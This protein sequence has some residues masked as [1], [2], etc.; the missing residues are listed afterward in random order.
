M[1]Y[2]LGFLSTKQG[3]NCVF[4]VVDQFS[5]MAILTTYKK[6]VIVEYTT[7]IF[8]ERVWVHFGIP[9]TIIL[10]RYNR[11]LKTFRL[12]LW[13]LLDTKLTK[14]TS[15]HPQ[16][17]GQM[18]VCNHMTMHILH[19]YNYKHPCAWDKSIPYV[20]HS[21]NRCIHSSTDH[22]PF[23]LGLGFPLLGPIDVS[24]PLAPHRN[25]IPLIIL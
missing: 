4:A 23:Q 9:Y 17:D 22:I 5:Q 6:N 21:Y 8:F 25:N 7:N 2:I 20:Q 15:F 1:D 18:E 13:S 12:S 14:S 3:N 24:L 16:T 19:I 10:D 11:F